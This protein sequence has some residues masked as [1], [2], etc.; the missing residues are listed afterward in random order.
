VIREPTDPPAERRRPRPAQPL[1]APATFTLLH[2]GPSLLV[3]ACFVAAAAAARHRLPDLLTDLR[4]VAVML[5][6]QF[7]IGAFNDLRDQEG[8]RV[9]K[10]GKPLASGAVSPGVA[11]AATLAGFGIA[12]GTAATFHL[13]TLPLTG[14]CAA[15]GIVYDL[16]LKRGALSW[17]PFWVGFACLPLTAGAA[18]GQLSAR[19]AVAAPPLALALA[20]S[21]QLANALPDIE[22]DRRSGS[23]GLAVRLGAVWA[24]RLS[25]GLAALAGVAAIAAAPALSQPI[26]AVALGAAPLLGVAL[27]LV[28]HPLPRPFPLLAPAAGMLAAVWLLAL[29]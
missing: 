20:L 3:T 24:R 25:L 8:D 1:R 28:L 2:P 27:L 6:L 16:G 12:L 19:V 21:I 5:P 4:L 14:A 15:A 11:V 29:P 22:A 26:A 7:A 18:V 17:L 23:A 9:A 13:P 10:P